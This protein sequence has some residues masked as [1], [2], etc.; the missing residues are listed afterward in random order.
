MTTEA[1]TNPAPDLSEAT[2]NAQQ[3]EQSVIQ[4][5][6]Q[7]TDEQRKNLSKV[8]FPDSHTDTFDV[9]GKTR[10][11]R[12]LP[13]KYSRQVNEVLS[14]FQAKLD[15]GLNSSEVTDI[16]LLDSLLSVVDKLCDFYKWEDIKEE[17]DDGEV[18]QVTDLQRIVVNQVALQEANDF[19]LMP[20]RVLVGMMR[21]VEIEMTNLQNIYSGL[22]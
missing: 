4:R 22:G 16:N 20:L 7:L 17:L 9:L 8:L 19:L 18:L 11:L 13:I 6:Q 5:T 10:T 14:V 21:H 1:Q 12:P 2:V 3:I 15:Q